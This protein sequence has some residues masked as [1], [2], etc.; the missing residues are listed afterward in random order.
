MTWLDF[1]LSKKEILVFIDIVN[2]LR[3]R[4][5]YKKNVNSLDFLN[6]YDVI[7]NFDQFNFEIQPPH[8]KKFFYRGGKD[9]QKKRLSQKKEINNYLLDL[10]D[11]NY[12]NLKN[13]I[14][15]FL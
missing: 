5:S 11:E 13:T 14:F 4:S 1:K 6:N 7:K 3:H 15:L 12:N 2:K 8:Q 9:T 10:I